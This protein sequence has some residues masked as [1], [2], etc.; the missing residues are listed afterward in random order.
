MY[1]YLSHLECTGCFRKLSADEPQNLCRQC[2]KVLYARYDLKAAAASLSKDEL[3]GRPSTM[4]RYHELLPVQ[5]LAFLT[6][7]GE[8][9][10]P[11]L[12][13][14][15]LGNQL[16]CPNLYIKD[17]A[18]NPTGSFKDRGLSAAVSRAV[19]LGLTRLGIPSAGNAAGSMAAYCSRAGLEAHV[20]LP[21]TTPRANVEECRAYGAK[22]AFGPGS[23]AEAGRELRRLAA[24]RGLFDVS[25]LGEPYRLEGKK[26]LGFEVA[27]QLGWRLPD[28]IV[29]PMG[30]GTG[31]LGMWKAFE[32]MEELG[33]LGGDRPR[34][35]S[36]Q[37]AGCAPIVK[38]FHQGASSAEPCQNPKTLA[39]GL[40]VPSPL[41]DYLI[42]Q[43]IRE[44]GGTA[45][46]VADEEMLACVKEMAASEGIF[47]CPEGAATLAG[48]KKL[49][50]Q[51][52]VSAAETILLV[53]TGSGMKYLDVLREPF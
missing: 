33:W 13:A 12:K 16:G 28:V 38:A 31:L 10:T 15:R 9:F 34:M 4:W 40:R 49:V 42:L 29:Y 3:A 39:A 5:G 46:D 27:E 45:L 2:G 43:V 1:S 23:I 26:T 25:T 21:D 36:V 14:E 48:L 30:G 44:S 24:K 51:G 52:M 18:G 22:L 53:N 47:P 17:E 8:G 11:L 37:A 32:E 7:L 50:D 41:G 35:V 6:T 20:V 19:E